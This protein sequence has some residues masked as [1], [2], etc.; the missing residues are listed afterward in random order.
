MTSSVE[1][2]SNTWIA[3]GAYFIG[4][5]VLGLMVAYGYFHFIKNTAHGATIVAD[6]SGHHAA[7]NEC[8][9]TTITTISPAKMTPGLYERLWRLCGN[10]IYN[11]LYLD[12]FVIR[13]DKL[14]QQG[15]DERVNLW[16]VV[17]ITISGV[18]LSGVQLFMSYKLANLGK[19]DFGRDSQLT[20]ESGKVSLQSSIIGI[21]ILVLSLAFFM[22]YVVYIYTQHDIYLDRPSNLQTPVE[23]LG[24]VESPEALAPASNPPP[25]ASPSP[26][27]SP[28]PAPKSGSG[29]SD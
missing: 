21:F 7:M 29:S 15:L 25:I 28:S 5:F 8:I 6:I 24:T 17:T 2:Y 9:K 4:A 3:R 16:L 13:R 18:F 22:I 23:Q 1:L 11:G 20:I 19:A 27:A 14:V 10:Q 12:D 26:V